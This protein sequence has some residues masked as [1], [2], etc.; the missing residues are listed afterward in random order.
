MARIGV[1][2][3]SMAIVAV[4]AALLLDGSKG[5]V[6]LQARAAAPV[7]VRCDAYNR[8]TSRV[9]RGDAV[10]GP[11]VLIGARRTPGR[12]RDSFDGR[13]FKLPLTLP[14][15]MSA[16]LTVPVSLQGRVGLVY[17]RRAQDA[18]LK[19]GRGADSAVRF[20]SCKA[21]ERAGRSGWPGGII[22][23][24]PRCVTLIVTAD[25]RP[26]ERARVPIGRRC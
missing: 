18:V 12:R 3:A 21:K 6:P 5:P 22:V 9:S 4:A 17:R 8:G 7:Q 11:F 15:G 23:D 20:I 14:E 26:P 10:A 24:R 19:S 1:V 2:L 25:G 13:G 16:T